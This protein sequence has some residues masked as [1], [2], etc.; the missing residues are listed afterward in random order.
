MHYLQ[1]TYLHTYKVSDYD[2]DVTQP[3][4]LAK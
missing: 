2:T 3:E 1:L 4:G